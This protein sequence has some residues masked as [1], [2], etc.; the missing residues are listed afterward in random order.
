MPPRFSSSSKKGSRDARYLSRVLRN[1]G[2]GSRGKC[3]GFDRV[4]DE[5]ATLVELDRRTGIVE[6]GIR[7]LVQFFSIAPVISV[8]MTEI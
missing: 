7:S 2:T 3:A 5:L 6:G 8:Q 4:A 1:S